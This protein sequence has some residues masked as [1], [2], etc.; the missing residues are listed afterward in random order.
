MFKRESA[1][2]RV[3]SGF[4]VIN[5]AVICEEENDELGQLLAEVEETDYRLKERSLKDRRSG[6][7]R[8]KRK[9]NAI[10]QP[11]SDMN[12]AEFTK[13]ANWTL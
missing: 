6:V 4:V 12:D 5:A 13:K 10:A 3:G 11:P 8:R 2:L 7:K 9:G 1:F